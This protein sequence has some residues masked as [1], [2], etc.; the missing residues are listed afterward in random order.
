MFYRDMSAH[1]KLA[2]RVRSLSFINLARTKIRQE[3]PHISLSSTL[4]TSPIKDTNPHRRMQHTMAS[5]GFTIDFSDKCIIVTG[6]NRGIGYA[7]SRAVAQAGARVA[8]IY[9]SSEDAHEVAEKLCKEFGVQVKA[10]Q[11]DVSDAEKTA[12]TFSLIDKDLGPVTGLIANAG[13]SIVKPA[14]ELTS[15]DFYKV[16]SVN[17]LGVFNSTKAAAR[18]WIDKKQSGGSIVITS[19]MSSQIINQVAPNKPLTQVFYNSSKG[20]VSMLMK[21]LAAE[22]A[23]HG[24]R[25]NALSPGYVNTDQTS[26]METHVLEHQTKT[27]PLGRFAEVCTK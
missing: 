14:L 9:R 21:G 17:V 13:V 3:P 2:L 7:Y 4:H 8:I 11:C 1:L 15:E 20:A 27:V 25:V 5:K 10:Y 18:L 16:Y 24:I 12:E 26:G 19:S 23:T 6:G 22:W